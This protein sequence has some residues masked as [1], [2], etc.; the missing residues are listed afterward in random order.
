MAEIEKRINQVIENIRNNRNRVCYQNLQTYL[1]RN[2]PKV[3]MEDLKNIIADMERRN[4]IV[5][6]G[7][8][9]KESFYVCENGDDVMYV[10]DEKQKQNGY[11]DLEYFK[12]YIDNDFYQDII[13]RIKSEVK[14]VLS[15]EL[16][17]LKDDNE[18]NVIKI[19]EVIKNDNDV[20]LQTLN[21]EISFL[22]KE[23]QSKDAIIQKMFNEQ[24]LTNNIKQDNTATNVTHVNNVIRNNSELVTEYIDPG[25]P[26]EVN[27][28]DI[29]N[30]SE[31]TNNN[32]E[33]VKPRNT[34]KNKR[35]ITLVGDSIIKNIEQHRMQKCLKSNEKIYVKSF[36]GAT[37]SD[38]F[39]YISPS[40]R[41]G[42]E[43]YLLHT[44]S[45]DLRSQSTPQE[46][47]D[48]IIK[49][50][51]DVKTDDNEVV[52]SSIVSRDDN[53]NAK[54]M[55]V[56]DFLKT[57][58]ENRGFGFINNK[59]IHARKHLNGSG[60]HLNFNGTIELANNFLD[61]IKV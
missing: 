13:N 16:K 39:D 10:R 54:G 59:N 8:D 4:V 24:V 26:V 61:F 40:K 22:R 48:E 38:M 52:I 15:Y 49:L 44:G 58:C 30:K 7:K 60:L 17:L 50:A 43:V 23:L 32:F 57:K 53:L 2:E 41:Y 47:S 55:Q 36:S 19:P 6:K 37:T 12:S 34:I 3:E 35:R 45:N 18:L 56:N 29:E 11:E 46:I 31:T 20:L 9:D 5:N 51:L 28:Q 1:N 14:S 33:T 25:D 42:S 21:G 27:I